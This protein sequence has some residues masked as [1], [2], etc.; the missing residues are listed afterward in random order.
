MTDL[1]INDTIEFDTLQEVAAEA[2]DGHD[3][4]S[5]G[6]GYFESQRTPANVAFALVNV[7]LILAM[8][9]IFWTPMIVLWTALVLVPTIM[10]LIVAFT[11]GFFH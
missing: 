4:I 5:Q 11:L 9:A 8:L 10:T 3:E 7:I 1:A 6:I 2:A